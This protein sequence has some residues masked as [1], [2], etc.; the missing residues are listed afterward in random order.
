MKFKT[1]HKR[2]AIK[3]AGKSNADPYVK[4]R[5]GKEIW[6]TKPG[7]KEDTLLFSHVFEFV[8]QAKA[9]M[10]STEISAIVPK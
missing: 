6:L 4:H 8:S 2:I 5:K 7:N 9:W 10:N 3:Q 1:Q